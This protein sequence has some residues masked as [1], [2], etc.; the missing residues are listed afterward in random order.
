MAAPWPRSWGPRTLA[1][2]PGGRAAPRGAAPRGAGRRPAPYRWRVRLWRLRLPF[3]AVMLGCAAAVTVAEL[4]PAPPPQVDIVVAARALEPGTP[5]SA[6]DLRIVGVPPGT[7]A[8]GAHGRP[9][10]VVGRA[11][12]VAL[13]AGVPVVDAL[14]RDDRLASAGPPGTVVVPV[15][16]AD[17]GVATLLR[18]GDRVDLFAAATSASGS[19]VAERLAERALVLPHPS[20]GADSDSSGGLLGSGT[21]A[22]EGTLTL[23]A[24]APEQA[25]SLAGASAWAG[26]SAVVVE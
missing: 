26:I 4:R 13:P 1:P 7:V 20:P 22:A 10:A 21:D 17:P 6:D 25:S 9:D 3:A 19:P 14:L 8:D 18:P 12:V 5:L 2:G 23:V 11:V 16:L 15:R 24:V